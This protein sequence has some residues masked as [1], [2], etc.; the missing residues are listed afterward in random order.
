MDSI[1][2]DTAEVMAVVQSNITVQLQSMNVQL[3][4]SIASLNAAVNQAKASIQADVENVKEDIEKYTVATNE[5]FAAENDFVKYQL[6]GTVL[7]GTAR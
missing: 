4:D 6:A 2:A 3:S 5:Q 7:Y 1:V